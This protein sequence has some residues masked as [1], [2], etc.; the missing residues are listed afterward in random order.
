[1]A[2]YTLRNKEKIAQAFDQAY[3]SRMV[4]SLDSHFSDSKEIEE[5]DSGDNRYNM[6]L[7]D[8]IG[9]SVNMFEFYIIKKT[10]DVYLLAFKGIIG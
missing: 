3:L 7:V 5:H 8:D 4:S 6:I 10:Y 2:R 1:M 9:H